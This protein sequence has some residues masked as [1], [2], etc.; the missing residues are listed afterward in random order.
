[1]I[2]GLNQS[3]PMDVDGLIMSGVLFSFVVECGGSFRNLYFE[4]V[5]N[6]DSIPAGVWGPITFPPE[7]WAITDEEAWSALICTLDANG[8]PDTITASIRTAGRPARSTLHRKYHDHCSAC[9]YQVRPY[10]CLS[11]LRPNRVSTV[12]TVMPGPV[13]YTFT[14]SDGA[15]WSSAIFPTIRNVRGFRP[16]DDPGQRRT[17]GHRWC[18]T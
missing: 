16:A 3:Q 13:D 4:A 17:D 2:A 15:P 12:A 11:C 10:D 9:P 6:P 8:Q 1:M 14:G 7:H 18:A 5:S